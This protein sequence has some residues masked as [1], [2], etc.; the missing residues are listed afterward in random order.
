MIKI[1]IKESEGEK[2]IP[3]PYFA[4]K[5]YLLKAIEVTGNNEEHKKIVNE[6]IKILRS[7]AKKNPGFV[8]IDIHDKEGTE[9]KITL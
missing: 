5:S 9:V 6:T 8:L 7:Y 1:H 2:N 4:I 3:L